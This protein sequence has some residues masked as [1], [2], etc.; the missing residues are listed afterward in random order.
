VVTDGARGD[1]RVVDIGADRKAPTLP[2]LTD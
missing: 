1:R 2:K